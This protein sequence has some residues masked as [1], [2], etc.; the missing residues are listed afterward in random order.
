MIN[1]VALQSGE[2]VVQANCTGTCSCKAGIFSCQPIKCTE[3]E[4]CSIKDGVL[5]CVHGNNSTFFKYRF[6]NTTFLVFYSFLQYFSLIIYI[7]YIR[8]RSLS[9]YKVCHYCRGLDL[10]ERLVVIVLMKVVTVLFLSL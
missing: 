8:K 7:N 9:L 5:A 6:V 2:T 10:E 4:I 1:Y 3:D